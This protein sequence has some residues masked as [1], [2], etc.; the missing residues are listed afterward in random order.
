MTFNEALTG[1]IDEFI[2]D[3]TI[4]TRESLADALWERFPGLMRKESGRL[5]G[6]QVWKV[7]RDYARR[8]EDEQQLDL[9][10]LAPGIPRLLV[11]NA[12]GFS[13][14]VPAAIACYEELTLARN[15]RR[16]NVGAVS[17]RFDRFEKA[18]APFLPLMEKDLDMTLAE[19]VSMVRGA[20]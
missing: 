5:T 9:P 12:D 4:V 10:G 15:I 14:I 1:L 18:I 2:G 7:A 6:D 11:L 20:A 13:R 17:A 16:A 8:E 3:G 19:A